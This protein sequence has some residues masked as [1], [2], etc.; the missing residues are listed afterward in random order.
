[1]KSANREN[2]GLGVFQN[3]GSVFT[4]LS[5]KSPPLWPGGR[6]GSDDHKDVLFTDPLLV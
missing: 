6:R 1:M 2:R 3:P 4:L 5:L